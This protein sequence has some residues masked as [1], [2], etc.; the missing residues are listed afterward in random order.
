MSS[1]TPAQSIRARLEPGPSI[2]HTRKLNK[3]SELQDTSTIVCPAGF[4]W[5]ACTG[6]WHSETQT[7]DPVRVH[8][9]AGGGDIWIGADPMAAPNSLSAWS[10]LEEIAT[11]AGRVF[12]AHLIVID[13]PSDPR[14]TAA[15]AR[16]FAAILLE[17]ADEVDV[18]EAQRSI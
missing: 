6:E 14:V 18:A 15:Q 11:P 3:M 1:A 17:L 10:A 12:G 8:G 16:E 13:P 7:G 9:L 4:A 5:C 2:I